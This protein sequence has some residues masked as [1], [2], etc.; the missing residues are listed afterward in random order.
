MR[1]VSQ[2]LSLELQSALVKQGH[3]ELQSSYLYLNFAYWFDN[4]NFEG[5]ASYFRKESEEERKHSLQIFDYLNVRGQK[6][7]INP[8]SVAIKELEFQKPGQLFE[9]FY[10]REQSNYNSLDELAKLALSQQE[11]LTH[12]FISSMLQDQAIGCDSAEKLLAKARAYN[13]FSGLYY[14]LDE[15]IKKDA[16]FDTWK[17]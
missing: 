1:K 17:S 12:K 16:S 13:Q 11:S 6:V 2:I 7:H 14:H 15:Q 4:Q 5:I 3:V 8:S 10:D 9:A